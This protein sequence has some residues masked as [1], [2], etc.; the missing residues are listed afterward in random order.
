MS[1]RPSLLTFA[2]TLHLPLA[3]RSNVSRAEAFPACSTSWSVE[4]RTVS[5]PFSMLGLQT[6]TTWSKR[7]SQQTLDTVVYLPGLARRPGSCVVPATGGCCFPQSLV[8]RTLHSLAIYRPLLLWSRDSAGRLHSATRNSIQKLDAVTL[9]CVGCALRTP[10]AYTV[11]YSM[12]Q[13]LLSEGDPRAGEQLTSN[14][15]RRN[16]VSLE[17]HDSVELPSAIPRGHVPPA[18]FA[19]AA[20]TGSRRFVRFP[21][22]LSLRAEFRQSNLGICDDL[23]RKE[24]E[25]RAD[26]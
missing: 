5:I 20:G 9:C 21:N 1:P 13:A 15:P 8:R 22:N 19:P 16:K 6:N 17:R 11:V 3:V 24:L 25:R 7:F 18:V 14:R 23:R 10:V 2:L 12:S 26:C 4:G